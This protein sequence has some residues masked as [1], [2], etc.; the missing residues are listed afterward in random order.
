MASP[1]SER[2][3]ALF[4]KDWYGLKLPI[5][6]RRADWEAR[7][8][9]VKLSDDVTVQPLEVA[10]VRCDRVS[11]ADQNENA[12]ILH[13]HGGGFT[14]GSCITHRRLAVGLSKAAS[15]PV[16]QVD[17]PLAPESP[18]PAAIEAVAQVYRAVL[19]QG[20]TSEKVVFVGDSAGGCL[21]AS[22]IMFLRDRGLPIPAGAFF[23][24]AGF[25]LTL[26]GESVESRK[27]IDPM[28]FKEGLEESNRYYLNG[29]SPT[30]PLASPLFG[31]LRM[32]PPLLI[33]AG[34]D[35]LLMSDSI[36]FAEKAKKAGVDVELE[37]WEEMWHVWHMC[38]GMIPEAD[39]ALRKAG[40]FIR[41]SLKID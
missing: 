24:G 7:E 35:D 15:V 13:L 29:E 16:L 21:V 41:R 34:T 9:K 11:M 2:L 39:E 14:Q 4:V 25:D 38:V 30:N 36:R 22:T 32:F 18:F 33:H 3:R 8:S 1:E 6:Q 26:S 5:Q 12:L 17:Y 23:M 19:E 27:D 20:L 10:G 37:V 40:L 31:D 28:L